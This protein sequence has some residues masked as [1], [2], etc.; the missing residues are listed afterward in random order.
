MA[1]QQYHDDVPYD[2]R[3]DPFADEHDASD[4]RGGAYPPSSRTVVS[5]TTPGQDN[6][7][8]LAAGGGIAGI[9]MGVA[10]TNERG[11]GILARNA[12]PS[13]LQAGRGQSGDVNHV[14]GAENPYVPEPPYHNARSVQQ[15]DPFATPGTLTPRTQSSIHLDDHNQDIYLASQ[16]SY[17]DN[18]YKRFSAPWD[19]RVANVGEIHPDEIED[20][21]DDG[22]AR[23][24]DSRRRS[25]LSFGHMSDRPAVGAAGAA[26]GLMGTGGR[27][28]G[29]PPFGAGVEKNA[30]EDENIGTRKKL[31]WLFG[32]LVVLAILGIITGATIAGINGSRHSTGSTGETAAQ[33]D[34]SG[35]LNANSD[36]I[37]ALLN[38]ANLHRVFPGVDYTPFNA[39][40]PACLSNPPSQNNVTRDMAVLSQLTKTIRLYGTD[41]NQTDMVLHSI[42]QLGLTDMSVWLAVWLDNNQTTNDRGISA[43]Y[44]ILNRNG[45]KPFAGVILGNE[46]LFRQDMTLTQLESVVTGVRSNFTS[47]G[48]SLPIAV[49]DLGDNWQAGLTAD[50]DVVMSNIHPFF[51]GV[52]ANVAAGWVWDFWQQH[53]VVLTQG[54]TKKNIISEVGWPSG[55]GNDCGAAT[56]SDS[57]QGSIAG[58]NEM[59]TFMESFVCQSLSNGTDFFW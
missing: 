20:D 23:P 56:C 33:D 3:V 42:N 14:A 40:Y 38:N 54:S 57:T 36:E 47:T 29:S 6:M 21:G 31:R 1:A 51:A 43:M 55:G 18:P 34:A 59:N 32:S 16:P 44:D 49:A 27:G 30:W 39:Q 53:D 4:S 48:I 19:P 35:D 5:S 11:S 13:T 45:V 8:V 22:F 25:M 12:L 50:V 41:C 46:V 37:K 24:P 7:G 2:G 17:A 26:G 28:P 52:T 58:I 10:N 9:A 15:S